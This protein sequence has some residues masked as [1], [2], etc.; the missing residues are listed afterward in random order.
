MEDR[1]NEFGRQHTD[2]QIKQMKLLIHGFIAT[3]ELAD[4]FDAD[5]IADLSRMLYS[6]ATGVYIPR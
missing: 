5:D 6:I 3:Y 4:E 2:D 1:M